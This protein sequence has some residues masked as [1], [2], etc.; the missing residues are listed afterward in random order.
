MY[1]LP[2]YSSSYYPNHQILRL[3]G[4][5]VSITKNTGLNLLKQN[6]STFLRRCLL[7]EI[8]H[9]FFAPPNCVSS[10]TEFISKNFISQNTFQTLSFT[11]NN[12]ILI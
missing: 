8:K 2:I 1:Y 4:A 6:T 10:L 5:E 3:Y 9:A 7:R 11:K 12:K